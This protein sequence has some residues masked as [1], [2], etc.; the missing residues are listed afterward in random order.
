MQHSQVEEFVIVNGRQIHYKA[1]KLPNPTSH[2]ERES[3]FEAMV[4]NAFF[5]KAPLKVQHRPGLI[6]IKYRTRNINIIFI[7]LREYFETHDWSGEFTEEEAEPW[8]NDDWI[9]IE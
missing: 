4:Y 6:C 2:V 9:D 1:L 8:L 7:P 3:K 5:N